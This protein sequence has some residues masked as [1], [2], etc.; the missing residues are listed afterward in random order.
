[1]GEDDVN[2][3]LTRVS[4]NYSIV[5][6]G[7]DT[8]NQLSSSI[9]FYLCCTSILTYSRLGWV[10]EINYLELER[11]FLGDDITRIRMHVSLKLPLRIITIV[12]CMPGYSK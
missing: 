9:F 3:S 6:S 8:D 5:F 12:C 2:L 11:F 7:D 1:M 10:D 4:M